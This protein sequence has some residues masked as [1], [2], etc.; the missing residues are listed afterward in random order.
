MAIAPE[1]NDQLKLHDIIIVIGK[2]ND[3]KR[4]A[5]FK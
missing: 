1:P 3:I 4:M 2:N 5:K